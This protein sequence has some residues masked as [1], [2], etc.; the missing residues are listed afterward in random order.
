MPARQA[1]LPAESL[2]GAWA[3]ERNDVVVDER[4]HAHAPHASYDARTQGTNR[5]I[6]MMA[7]KHLA[8]CATAGSQKSTE[9][10]AFDY[11]P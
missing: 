2:G 6:S 4:A 1:V 3:G 7:W 10:W 11:K 9:T 5:G 8:C